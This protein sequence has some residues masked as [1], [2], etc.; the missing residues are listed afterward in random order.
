MLFL[1]ALIWLLGEHRWQRIAAVA[2]LTP[3]ILYA[4]FALGLSVRLP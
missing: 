4:V 1:A 2:V 3:L